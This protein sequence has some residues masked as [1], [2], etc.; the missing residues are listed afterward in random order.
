MGQTRSAS[1][2]VA[3]AASTWRPFLEGQV[4]LVTGASQGLGVNIATT[5]GALG[6]R[7]AAVQRRDAASTV[8]AV[9]QAG[10]ECASYRADL[11][12]PAAAKDAVERVISDLGRLDILVCNAA[13]IKITPALD[14]QLEDWSRIV[15]LNLNS[16]FA[17]AQAAARHFVAH[18]VAGRIVLT[19]STLSFRGGVAVPAYSAS[20]GGV[21]NLVR[22]L[23]N[24]WAP[25]GIRVN[26][27]APGYMATEMGAYSVS[28]AERAM[29]TLGRIPLG[30]QA[31]PQEIAD[32][33]AFLVSPAATYVHGHNLV[34]DGGWMGR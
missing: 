20:K 15:D 9:R 24:E 8:D 34:V 26:G 18:D 2:D 21:A 23:A 6:A 14:L 13:A 12:D 31:D 16:L 7:V 5:L 27:I 3:G 10:G 19:S 1:S 22:A 4:A 17:M 33:V 32:A 11:S 28:T 29:W 30:R 25:L